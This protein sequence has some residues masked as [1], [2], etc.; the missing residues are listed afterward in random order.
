[1]GRAPLVFLIAFASTLVGSMS[2]GSTSLLSIPSW[3]AMGFPLPVALA[4][5]KLAGTVWTALGSRNYLHSRRLDT[6]L[7]VPM[8]LLGGAA[9]LVGTRANLSIDPHV[10]ER[11]VGGLIVVV[12]LVVAVLPRFGLHPAPPR[13]GRVPVVL[14]ALPLGFYEGVFGS[15][16][17]IAATLLFT[18]AR[19]FDLSEALGHYYVLACVWSVVAALAYIAAGY[20]DLGLFVPLVLGATAG[21]YLGSRIGSAWGPRFI[22]V[23]FVI[24]GLILGLKLLLGR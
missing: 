18:G 8:T 16:N 20:F 23:V 1:V 6:K 19:G 7:L 2:G 13:I 9:A 24:A 12:V 3:I 17:S 22:R 5:D 21:G 11:V 15:G 4:C 14:A 10:L